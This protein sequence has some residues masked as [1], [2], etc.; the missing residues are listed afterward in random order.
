MAHS[1]G[2]S[3]ELHVVHIQRFPQDD[4]IALVVGRLAVPDSMSLRF[5]GKDSLDPNC[6]ETGRL[7]RIGNSQAKCGCVVW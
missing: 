3:G 1:F 5:G 2:D 4:V 7:N 6:A